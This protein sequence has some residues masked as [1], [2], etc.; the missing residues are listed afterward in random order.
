MAP[1]PW[2]LI[3]MLYEDILRPYVPG[4]RTWVEGWFGVHDPNTFASKEAGF[5]IK[6]PDGWMGDTQH[7]N[8]VLRQLGF[9]VFVSAPITI[10]SKKIIG[11]VRPNINVVVEQTGKVAIAQYMDLTCQGLKAHGWEVLRSTADEAMDSG[12]VEMRLVNP[13]GQTLMQ[14]QKCFHRNGKVFTITITELPPEAMEKDPQAI[15]EIKQIVQSFQF[16]AA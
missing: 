16:I 2:K 12:S 1:V 3:E 7:G 4:V 14:L 11:M 13:A 5:T 8:N 9:P 10:F 15:D 6:W